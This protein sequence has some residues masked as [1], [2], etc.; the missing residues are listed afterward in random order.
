MVALPSQHLDWPGV[1]V[2]VINHNGMAVLRDTL[3][4]LARVDYP[5]LNIMLVDDQSGD[6]SVSFVNAHYPSVRI[7]SVP[8]SKHMPSVPRNLA[9]HE[10]TTPYVLLL[11]NDVAMT[12]DSIKR[13]MV[14]MLERPNTFRATPRIVYHN[15]PDRIYIDGGG[16]NY[17]GISARSVR[18]R[19]A[20]DL[21][22]GDLVPSIGSGIMLVNRA[23]ALQLDGF[24]EGYLFGWGEDAE[25]AVRARM[26]GF[27][28]W[29]VPTALALHVE[30]EHG[31]HRAEAQ[32]YN[33]YRLMLI[34]YSARGLLLLTPAIAAFDLMMFGL[35]L[36]KGLAPMHMRATLR[37][38][39][40]WSDIMRRRR[41]VQQ[42]RAVG[43]ASL[44]EGTPILITGVLTHSSLL[45]RVATCAS[46]FFIA[47]WRLV[48]RSLSNEPYRHRPRGLAALAPQ[49][50]L[51]QAPSQRIVDSDFSTPAAA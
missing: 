41:Y 8:V 15:D 1:T 2:A 26:L 16:L 29:T 36:L 19:R 17:L 38:L 34:N 6:G 23:V 9:L 30:K 39:R 18:G 49:D 42:R 24:D 44:L 21:P 31:T 28:T 46:G 37:V 7:V 45:Q 3:D 51:A 12:P 14:V 4:A 40:D 11:D 10:A 33:R 20:T 32:F 48:R 27:D 25:L 43:D 50:S 22:A 35:G 5:N 13:L 47:Y